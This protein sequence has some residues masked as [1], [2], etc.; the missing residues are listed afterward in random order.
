MKNYIFVT[1]FLVISS[2]ALAAQDTCSRFREGEFLHLMQ[3]LDSNDISLRGQ[4]IIILALKNEIDQLE[5]NVNQRNISIDLTSQ[6]KHTGTAL[7]AKDQGTTNYSDHG[8]SASYSASVA[9][10]KKRFADKAKADLARMKLT[11]QEFIHEGELIKKIIEVKKLKAVLS[12]TKTKLPLIEKKID[13]YELLGE[14]SS[15]GFKELADAELEKIKVN[16][17]INN[18]I[19]RIEIEAASFNKPNRSLEILAGELNLTESLVSSTEILPCNFSDRDTAQKNQEITV[20]EYELSQSENARLPSVSIS[21][22]FSSRDYHSGA[23]KNNFSFGIGISTPLYDGGSSS[24]NLESKAQ[25]L[26]LLKKEKIHSEEQHDIK[27]ENFMTLENAIT[28]SISESREK[29]KKLNGEIGELMERQKMGQSNFE[30]LVTKQIQKI[31]IEIIAEELWTRLLG[32][33]ANHW[34]NLVA[35]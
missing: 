34:E 9:E 25:Q 10:M 18:L 27:L 19:S 12:L 21:S 13:Y 20:A 28:A 23:H 30:E 4:N 33:W 5:A 11:S 2:S 35:G 15:G 24:A 22:S 29:I 31:D 6:Y 17:E 3:R 1:L 26:S 7:Y 16:N 8:I 32:V 14:L